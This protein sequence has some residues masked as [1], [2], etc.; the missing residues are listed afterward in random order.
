MVCEQRVDYG[1]N[2]WSKASKLALLMMNDELNSYERDEP[3][4][5]HLILN[6]G[7]LTLF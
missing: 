7:T 6:Q 3:G 4:N 1:G 2:F 5:A